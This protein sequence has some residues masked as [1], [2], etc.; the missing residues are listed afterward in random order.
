MDARN[1]AQ[2]GTMSDLKIAKK[3]G[4]SVGAVR[5]RR[6]KLR[7]PSWRSTTPRHKRRHLEA[8]LD[9]TLTLKQ[10]LFACK[11]FDNKCAYCGKERF[12]TEDHLV[13][14]SKGGPRTALNIIPA[15]WECNYSKRARRAH[16]WIY[17]HFE[18]Q[19]GKEIVDRIVRYLTEVSS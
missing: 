7:T 14:L 9:N 16:L 12:L 13:P 11:W 15:C 17:E 19:E 8:E 10:W 4:I 1:G 5:R 3:L 6:E 18:M 2:L